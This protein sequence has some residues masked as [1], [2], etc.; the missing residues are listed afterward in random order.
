MKNLAG[1]F[2]LL[3]FFLMIWA[4]YRPRR[5]RFYAALP[6]VFGLISFLLSVYFFGIP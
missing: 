4:V 3:S 6:F 1:A 5:T 2:G